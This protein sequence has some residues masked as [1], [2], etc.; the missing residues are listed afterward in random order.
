MFYMTT[1]ATDSNR[2]ILVNRFDIWKKIASYAVDYTLKIR[3]SRLLSLKCFHEHVYTLSQDIYVTYFHKWFDIHNISACKRCSVN[4]IKN[5]DI[6]L[7]P[8]R[9]LCFN[10][11][12]RIKSLP[13][14]CIANDMWIPHM[15]TLKNVAKCLEYF[16]KNNRYPEK[17]CFRFC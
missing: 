9:V 13:G 16:R 1:S 17:N 6:L 12:L 11:R 15:T 5:P 10:K 3:L 4:S 2:H 7:K 14:F 8:S